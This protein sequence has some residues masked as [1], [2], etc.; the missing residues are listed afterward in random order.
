[1][2]FVN[3]LILCPEDCI[4]SN[5]NKTIN[6]PKCNCDIVIDI[7]LFFSE[8]K[9]NKSKLYDSFDIEKN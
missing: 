2:N 8:I 5:Y 6:K 3:N 4:L 9:I 7:P 1:M